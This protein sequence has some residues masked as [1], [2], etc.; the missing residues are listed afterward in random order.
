M[1]VPAALGRPPMRRIDKNTSGVRKHAITAMNF[2]TA[3][4]EQYDLMI[5]A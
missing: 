1:P 3:D 4:V 5:E 2:D